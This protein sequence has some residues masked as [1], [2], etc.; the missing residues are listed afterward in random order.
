VRA[1][2]RS[3]R[4]LAHAAAPRLSLSSAAQNA[5]HLDQLSIRGNNI[6]YVILPDTLNLDA[7]LQDTEKKPRPPAASDRGRGRGRGMRGRGRGMRGGRGWG[8]GRA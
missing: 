5:V 2:A 6:R 1:R 8:R 4:R 7:L 3:S